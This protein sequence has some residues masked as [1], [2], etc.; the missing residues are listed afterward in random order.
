[1]YYINLK[2]VQLEHIYLNN[3]LTEF[4]NFLNSKW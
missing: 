1:M 4:Y 2:Y 3:S